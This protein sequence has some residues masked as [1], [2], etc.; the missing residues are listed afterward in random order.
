MWIV[1]HRGIAEGV[2]DACQHPA[3]AKFRFPAGERNEAK[4]KF[5]NLQI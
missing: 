3:E 1:N 2:R 4:I 5:I